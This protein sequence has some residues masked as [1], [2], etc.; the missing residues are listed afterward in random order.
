[1]N[2]FMLVDKATGKP[3]YG[4]QIFE[5]DK[6]SP[7]G[8]LGGTGQVSWYWVD[9]TGKSAAQIASKIA[10]KFTP[11][12]APKAADENAVVTDASGSWA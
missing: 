9:V 3:V 10:K 4:G 1:M 5:T 8:L 2:K 11:T 12:K 6:S 7:V